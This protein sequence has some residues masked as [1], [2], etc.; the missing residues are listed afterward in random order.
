MGQ[1]KGRVAPHYG[2][3]RTPDDAKMSFQNLRKIHCYPYRAEFALIFQFLTNVPI[4]TVIIFMY[5][6]LNHSV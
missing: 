6:M 4:G 5:F 1:R 2:L 3:K